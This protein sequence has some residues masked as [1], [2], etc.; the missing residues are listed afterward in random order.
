VA[1][2]RYDDLVQ[3]FQIDRSKLRG[4]L[5]RLGPALDTI[6]QRH[7][8]PDPVAVLL[9]EC[10][11]L[12]ATLADALKYDGVFT[13]QMKGD[14]PVRLL[15]ADVATGGRARPPGHRNLRGFAQFTAKNMP[16]GKDSSADHADLAELIGN[17][18]LAFTVDQ[19]PHTERYQGI[20]ELVGRDM[21][22]CIQHYFKQ[23]E[24][25]ET[26]IK[27]AVGRDL[28]GRWRGGAVMVQRLPDQ[29]ERSGAMAAD[30][31]FLS[32]DATPP[33]MADE[34]DWRRAMVMLA[35]CTRAEL[36]SQELGAQALLFRLFHEDGVRVYDPTP[37][38]DRCRCSRQRVIDTLSRLGS[39]EVESLTVQDRI[40]VTCE[41]CSTVYHIAEDEVEPLRRRRS[42]VRRSGG[43]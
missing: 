10:V 29:A 17:G 22:S 8:Y 2:H 34:D 13:L 27:I 18:L 23:S 40:E 5:V 31:D 35:S 42:V 37:V 4:R 32:D 36:L 14:G 15:V 3:P 38:D 30:E 6:L 25:L 28:A 21:E 1:D 43:A 9:G 41:F 11:T 39:G 12:A 20:V 26:G 33:G 24:Q 16:A 7:A 19:G